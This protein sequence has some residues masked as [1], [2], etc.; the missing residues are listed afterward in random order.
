MRCPVCLQPNP[1][2]AHSERAQNDFIQAADEAGE[3]NPRGP[4]RL[5]PIFLFV[6]AYVALLACLVYACVKA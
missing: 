6:I 5:R 1:C 4:G 3:P 2:P